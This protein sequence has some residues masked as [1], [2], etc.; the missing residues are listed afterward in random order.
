MNAPVSNAST[1]FQENSRISNIFG[2]QPQQS[3][4]STTTSQ[5]QFY[6]ATSSTTQSKQNLE[7]S[8]TQPTPLV[9]TQLPPPGAVPLPDPKT[10]P[11][12]NVLNMNAFHSTQSAQSAQSTQTSVVQQ[13]VLPDPQNPLQYVPFNVPFAEQAYKI[14]REFRN[15]I[16]DDKI[17]PA[18][19]A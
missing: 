1:Q 6:P 10:A 19:W 5:Y 3:Q 16:E 15:N 8:E 7:V 13:S 9:P 11:K 14:P 18:A 17:P 12:P 2:N 4:L